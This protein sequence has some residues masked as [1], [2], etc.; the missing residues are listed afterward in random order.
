L[1]DLAKGKNVMHALLQMNKL[2][3]NGLQQAYD[4]A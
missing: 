3:I 1:Q 4:A 2:D